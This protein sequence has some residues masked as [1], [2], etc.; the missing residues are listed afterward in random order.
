MALTLTLSAHTVIVINT[1]HGPIR[2]WRGSTE[3]ARELRIEAPA[4]Y[5]IRRQKLE[6]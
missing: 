5:E 3:D 6:D 1:P 2:I 4:G